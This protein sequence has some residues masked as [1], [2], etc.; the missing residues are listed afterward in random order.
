MKSSKKAT[1][2]LGLIVVTAFALWKGVLL[3]DMN[4]AKGRVERTVTF[5]EVASDDLGAL[6]HWARLRCRGNTVEKLAS[7]LGLEPQLDVVIAHIASGLP[8]K[9]RTAVEEVCREELSH[10]PNQEPESQ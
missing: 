5:T 1:L 8:P 7:A 10:R 9:S 4:G 6:K 3:R 2:I